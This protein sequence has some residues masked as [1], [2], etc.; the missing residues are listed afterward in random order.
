MFQ[1]LLVL[2]F[3][4][5][6]GCGPK[7]LKKTALLAYACR[8]EKAEKD[9]ISLLDKLGLPASMIANRTGIYSLENG[10]ESFVIRNWLF[11]NA[12]KTLD[13]QYY[14]FLRDKTGL[15]CAD[16]IVRAADR[17]VKIRI[18]LDDATAKNGSHEIYAL[19]AHANIDIKVYNPGVKLGSVF[20]RVKKLFT[21]PWHFHRRMHNKTL[22]ADGE[23]AI[24]GGRNIADEY[25]DYD[26]RYNFRDR[27]VFIVGR[28][29]KAVT[30]SFEDFW[31]SELSVPYKDL[32]KKT[33]ARN[34]DRLHAYVCDE[35]NYS[36]EMKNKVKNFPARFK[37]L[38]AEFVWVNNVSFVSDM[39]GKNE[40][41]KNHEGGICKDSLY[42]VLKRAKKTVDIQSSYLIVN[43]EQ[44]KVLTDLVKRGV[45]VRILTN[46]LCSI[47]N[48][49]AFS[50]YQRDREMILNTGIEVL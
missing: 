36:A 19:D 14:M 30:A 15:I 38:A 2:V 16:Y 32:S 42:A 46:S 35:R 21:T 24:S 40:N 37:T 10:G 47:D 27:D 43:D 6:I 45:K 31:N 12:Q 17:G 13:I 3:V 5:L 26:H 49:E 39:P 48:I 41:K 9:S 1:K 44:E 8:V 29:V 23:V 25:F 28:S 20:M 33:Q 4:L 7:Y 18:L 34:F 11:E 50:G 22:T